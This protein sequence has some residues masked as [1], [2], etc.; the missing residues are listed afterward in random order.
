M[1]TFD[2]LIFH[3]EL[4]DNSHGHKTCTSLSL[5]QQLIAKDEINKEYDEHT[6][7]YVIK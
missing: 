4:S 5:L 7:S 1:L 3:M 6:N 2:D